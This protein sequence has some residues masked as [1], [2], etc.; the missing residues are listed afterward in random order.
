MWGLA[1]SSSVFPAPAHN[2]A[3]GAVVNLT[4]ELGLE[5]AKHGIQVNAL[6]P[7]FYRTK[8]GDYDD[9]GFIS[10]VTAFIPMGRIAEAAEIKGPALF[11]ASAASDYMTGQTLVTDG[12]C[13]A[14]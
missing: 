4:R 3:K 8:L 14:K 12:G 11:L 2:A 7:G 13:M 9:P 1:S 5:Y 10:A 6:C